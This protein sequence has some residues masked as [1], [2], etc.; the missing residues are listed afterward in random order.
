VINN[1]ILWGVCVCVCVCV[2]EADNRLQP[3]KM[4]NRL[5]MVGQQV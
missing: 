4:L 3:L 2:Q 5:C 1:V